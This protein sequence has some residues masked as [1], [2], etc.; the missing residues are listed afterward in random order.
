MEKRIKDKRSSSAEPP[1][2]DSYVEG[3]I[4]QV[5]QQL[6]LLDKKLDTLVSQCQTRPFQR[7]DRPQHQG[8]APRQENN[9]RERVL[10]KAI[11]A[12][13][14]KECEV[15][16]KPTGD[17]PV[18]CK[19]CFSKR[20]AGSGGGGAKFKE[21]RDNKHRGEPAKARFF[22]RFV[23]EKSRKYGGRKKPLS[24]KRKKD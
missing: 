23:N 17:R 8:P 18:Y 21:N 6:I 4:M 1:R 13:C 11:C 5:Q 9:Y 14:N 10:H 24:R 12:D 3:M 2:V 22:D 20:K 15:P 7:F 19:E 16:F